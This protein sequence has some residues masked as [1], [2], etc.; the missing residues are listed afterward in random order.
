MVL[1]GEVVMFA[2]VCPAVLTVVLAQGPVP[3]LS[4]EGVREP[5]LLVKEKGYFIHSLRG[6]SLALL[7]TS[8]ATGAMKVLATGGTSVTQ[9]PPMGIDRLYYRQVRLAGVAA[10]RERLYVL[11]WQGKATVLLQGVSV[12][13]P[14]YRTDKYRLLVFRPDDGTLVHTLDLKETAIP[15]ETVDKGPLRLHGDGVACFGTR[16]EFRGT[17]LLRQTP[18]KV[19]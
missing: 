3:E 17:K 7:H 8:T 13:Q 6:N 15:K 12:G 10:D 9:S 1:Q 19:P 14:S 16:F 11:E 5:R 4:Q 2:T 18:D